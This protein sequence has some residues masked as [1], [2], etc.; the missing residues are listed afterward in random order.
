MTDADRLAAARRWVEGFPRTLCPHCGRW[1]LTLCARCAAR[2]LA[3]AVQAKGL[4]MTQAAWSEMRAK[5]WNDPNDAWPEVTAATL[6]AHASDIP[7][8]PE[9]L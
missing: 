9:A 8:P 1:A 4:E 2:V 6:R 7:E 3:A 5:F